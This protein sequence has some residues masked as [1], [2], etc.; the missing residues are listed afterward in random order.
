MS[1]VDQFAEEG[2]L[3]IG[4]AFDPS[5][6][7]ELNR[8]F[9]RQY[10]DLTTQHDGHRG[11]MQ[12]GDER[13]MLSVRLKGPFLDPQLYAHPLLIPVLQQLLGADM[14]LDNITCVIA[15]PG[16]GEQHLHRDHPTLF[17]EQPSLSA[18]MMS[19]AI[20]LVVPL[21]DL[22]PETGTTR[23]FPGTNR[24]EPQSSEVLPYVSR[25]ECYLM[26][27]R[28]KHQ[29]TPNVSGRRRPVLYIVYTRPWFIDVINLR[30]QAR[31]NIDRA[32]LIAIPPK[33]HPLFRRL[34]AKGTF[35]VSEKELFGP[36][37][38][39]EAKSER[40]LPKRVRPAQSARPDHLP[41]PPGHLPT[42]EG[43][44]SR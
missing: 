23:L 8:E 39:T 2:W 28:T 26:D 41:Q 17:Q 37:V 35:D 40:P 6:I 33:H 18:G 31:I 1:F 21:I 16:A 44:E 38:N 10:N 15:L 25:G 30:R 42:R 12:V 22:T 20:T 14:L 24:G 11:Y 19:Y 9:E 32:D 5:Y 7:D 43:A 13:L 34:A 36:L 27:Y 3:K 4:N 29:G